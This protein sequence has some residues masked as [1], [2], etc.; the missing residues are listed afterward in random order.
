MKPIKPKKMGSPNVKKHLM[1]LE[2]D[3]KKL[4]KRVEQS[5]LNDLAGVQ[6]SNQA[7]Q[8]K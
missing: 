5:G 3:T 2:V 1:N 8:Q 6:S 4:I 7:P